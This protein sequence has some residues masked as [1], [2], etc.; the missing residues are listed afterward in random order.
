MLALLLT[1]L[2]TFL[3][4]FILYILGRRPGL[5]KGWQTLG[6]GGDVIDLQSVDTLQTVTTIFS[7]LL[8]Y[9]PGTIGYR[10]RLL[11]DKEG[12]G[13][14]LPA[15]TLSG[16]VCIA[17]KDVETFDLAVVGPKESPAN[18]DGKA[19]N[20]FL[21]VSFTTPLL[22]FVLSSHACPIRPLGAVN[23]EN[24]FEFE[25]PAFCRDR[26]AILSASKVGSLTYTCYF[27]GSRR[28][29]R[30]HKRGVEFDILIEL[31]RD[32]QV[33]LRQHLSF[34]QFL[35]RNHAPLFKQSSS[36]DSSTTVSKDSKGNRT[37]TSSIRITPSDTLHWAASCGDY[38]PIHVSA[39]AA[40]LFGFSSVIAHG[41]YGVALAVQDLM[42]SRGTDDDA[43][44]L[45]QK[46]ADLFSSQQRRFELEVKFV[47]PM[48]LPAEL[49]VHWSG[50]GEGT[51]LEITRNGKAC[52][53]G[54][55]TG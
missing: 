33:V 15:L 43:D 32:E 31:K 20:P 50:E 38:N 53:T 40:K 8:K 3:S 34:L 36:G 25:D 55:V 27:G 26:R 30:R 52:I 23:T 7:I 1:A 22:L 5:I 41:N 49:I 4:S 11:P 17:D 18:G 9:V 54:R 45:K 51:G 48:L 37:A 28:P 14:Q 12:H 46:T 2:V 42:S 39:L 16:K 10:T 24:R 44:P 47:K 21:L 6:E 29:G 35:P 19:T 13:F